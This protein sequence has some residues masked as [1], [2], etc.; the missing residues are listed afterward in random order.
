MGRRGAPLQPVDGAVLPRK[1]LGVAARVERSAAGV[2]ELAGNAKDFAFEPAEGG[3]R[4]RCTV[5]A[6]EP[7]VNPELLVRALE[8]LEPGLAPDFAAW[9]RLEFYDAD[10]AV[11]R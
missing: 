5:S 1:V 7:T 2:L 4:L 8:Q 6:A 11:F 10:M 3:V 9:R